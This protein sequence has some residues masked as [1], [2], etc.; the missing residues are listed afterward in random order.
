MHN[1]QYYLEKLAAIIIIS[2]SKMNL[3]LNYSAARF[4]KTQ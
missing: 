1:P 3:L 4:S 2:F